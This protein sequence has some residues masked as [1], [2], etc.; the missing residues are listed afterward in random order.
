MS[1]LASFHLLREPAWRAPV[2]LGRLVGD[3]WRLSRVDGLRFFQVL[4]TGRGSST[5]VG[6]ISAARTALF[7]VWEEPD[8]L[9]DFLALTAFARRR[10]KA[11]ES[12]HVRLRLLGGHGRWQGCDV[13]DGLMR[14]TP[15]GP[16]AVLTRAEVKLRHWGRFARAARPVS[17]EVN[18]ADGLL[19]VVGMGE[20]PV[21]R[22]ATFSLWRD[23]ATLSS[24]AYRH[25]RHAEVVRRTREQGWYGE[26]LFARF[27][28][29]GATGTWDGRNPLAR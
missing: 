17:A 1:R 24:F 2:A 7:A 25:P 28:P 11:V 3:R 13:L 26:E 29:V 16:V 27:Q 15:G 4:G 9:A 18:T 5:S 10:A 8:A 14:G 12:W 19:A 20:A 6:G 22:Q 21:G 23:A